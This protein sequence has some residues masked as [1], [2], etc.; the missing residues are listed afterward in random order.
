MK[1]FGQTVINGM[2]LKNRIFMAPMGTQSENDGAFSDRAIRYY[3]ERAKGGFGLIITGA[4]MVTLNY[5]PK[6]A[7]VIESP[8][9]YEQMNFLARRI[10]Y[11]GAK[12]CIQLSPG[13]GIKN[14]NEYT[15]EDIR[16]LVKRTAEAAAMI[17]NAGVDAIELH[18][19]GGYLMDQFAS[20]LFNKREDEYGGSF[21]NRMRFSLEILDGVRAAVGPNYPILYKFTPVH[22]YPG[23]REMEEG[24]KMAQVLVDHGVDALHV[25]YGFHYVWYKAIDTVYQEPVTQMHIAREIKKHV[26][27]PVFG[28]GKMNNPED[29]IEA[30]AKGD[31]DYI[32]LAHMAICEPDW[33]KKVRNKDTLSI[34]PCIGC[35]EC[36]YTHT[37]GQIFH[38]A[39][40]PL[41]FA[42][43]YYDVRD[44]D[45]DK[46]LLVIGGGPAGLT[47]AITAAKRGIRVELW[48]KTNQLGGL[49]LAAGGPR[50]KKDV[51]DYTEY[52]IREVSKLP[53]EIKMLKEATKDEIMVGN[54]DKVIFATG[55]HPV[56]PPIEGLDKNNCLDANLLLRNNIKVGKK[57]VVVGG[58]LVGCE[59]AVH[60]AENADEV[61]IV[62]MMPEL[63]QTTKHPM[64]NHQALLQLMADNNIKSETNAY[65]K[66]VKENK[67]IVQRS[68]DDKLIEIEADTVIIAVGYRPNVSV[69]DQIIADVDCD[70][71]GDASGVDNILKAV[72]Q[73]FHIARSL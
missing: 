43:D 28:Q 53:I 10:H 54:F 64:N 20:E 13:F 32:G 34:R 7:N 3:E 39:V 29:V 41:T 14:C 69:F 36:L 25:D 65:V 56:I 58:G 8:R 46:K 24:L 37:T 16:F 12:L 38:C 51:K 61:T 44:V 68:D 5:E 27:V 40:N 52:L 70:L 49:L 19:Y 66:E 33:V 35:N 18:G 21:E 1:I 47:A 50:F 72:H 26:D 9:S 30:L 73:G 71:I 57:I 45:S 59:T 2:R 11:N 17:K 48:E 63:L 4:N 62:E 67:V 31:C 23:G 22:G 42:E 60:V 15:I 6:A 55:S